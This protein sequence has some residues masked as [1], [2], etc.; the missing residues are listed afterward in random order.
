MHCLHYREL[1]PYDVLNSDVVVFTSDTVPTAPDS[2]PAESGA[3]TEGDH[4]A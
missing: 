4:D 2:G 1:N 3:A